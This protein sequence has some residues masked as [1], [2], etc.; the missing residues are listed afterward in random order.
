MEF[1]LDSGDIN[2][3]KK[4]NQVIRIDGVTTNPSI[5]VKAG[6]KFEDVMPEITE[7]L[8]EDTPIHCQVLSTKYEDIVE[9]ALK[10]N[11][12]RKNIYV[13]IP[14]TWDG[15]RAIKT[16][17]AKGINITATTIFT[18]SQGIMAA[19]LGA[20]YIA[21]YVNRIDNLDSDGVD[22]VRELV[23]IINATHLETK[24]LAAS[25]RNTRQIM[26]VIAANTHS[27]TV[28]PDLVMGLLSHPSTDISVDDFTKQWQKTFG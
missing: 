18:V 11:K 20:K 7:E 21:P 4:Y 15:Y 9:E 6:K 2:L 28:G 12:L 1:L 8:G 27:L 26:G 25:F 13:K 3:I 19:R 23:E 16:L 17:A 22:V 5:L 14:V 24:V 10:I